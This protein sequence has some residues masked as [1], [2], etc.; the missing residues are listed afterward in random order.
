MLGS[1]ALVPF[2]L[3]G[4]PDVG[5]A[6]LKSDPGATVFI[7]ANHGAVAVGS[8][9]AEALH[10]MERAEFLAQVELAASQLGALIPIPDNQIAQMNALYG[11]VN[12][13]TPRSL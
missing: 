1:I 8:N 4:T 11:S 5:T 10:R 12:P 6:L 3:P 13:A 2:A 9:V 7:L